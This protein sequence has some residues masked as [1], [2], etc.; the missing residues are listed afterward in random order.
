MY[1]IARRCDGHVRYEGKVQLY[2]THRNKSESNECECKKDDVD[3][4]SYLVSDGAK[5]DQHLHDA[6]TRLRWRKKGTRDLGGYFM[7]GLL[8]VVSGPKQEL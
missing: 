4:D 6:S 8:V 7:F 1:D 5:A 2:I 3:L